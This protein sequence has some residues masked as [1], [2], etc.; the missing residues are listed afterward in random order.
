MNNRE[1]RTV[2]V[3]GKHGNVEEIIVLFVDAITIGLT[4]FSCTCNGCNL[5]NNLYNVLCFEETVYSIRR[6]SIDWFQQQFSTQLNSNY[7]MNISEDIKGQTSSNFGTSFN[8]SSPSFDWQEADFIAYATI[9]IM[10]LT[11]GCLVGDLFVT[12]FGYPT[13][14]GDILTGGDIQAGTGR[15]NW[16]GFVNGAVG[17]ASIVTFTEMSLVLSYSMHQMN[18]RFKLSRKT[19]FRLIGASWLYGVGSMSPP[20]FGWNRFVPGA[21][22]ISCAPDWTDVTPAGM[23][24]SIFLITAGFVLPILA[25]SVSCFKIFRLLRQDIVKDNDRIKLRRRRWQLNL[26]RLTATALAAFILSWSP[27]CF[28]SVISIFRGNNLLSPGEA[29]IP[30]L[31]AKASVIYNPFVDITVTLKQWWWNQGSHPKVIAV[32]K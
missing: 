22:K 25:I 11:L 18:P 9:M 24:Y 30:A 26:L 12:V 20:L 29:E 15:C 6:T 2:T 13:L 32:K 7:A 5:H 10:I 16:Y 14:M 1:N 21:S 27:Y 23:A 4:P 17:I 31:M 28:V 8:L 3:V 19:I